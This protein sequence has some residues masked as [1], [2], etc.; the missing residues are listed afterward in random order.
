ML[1]YQGKW[2]EAIDAL[3]HVPRDVSPALWSYHM[4]WPL[5]SLNRLP[6]ASRML[7]TVL[8][9]SA[10]DPGGNLYGARAM[11]R[12]RWGDRKGAAGDISAA[13]RVGNGYGHFHHTAYSIAAVYSVLGDLDKAQEWIEKAA[14]DGFPCYTLFKADPNLEHLRR[15]TRFRSFVAK[16]RRE[17]EHIPR[18]LE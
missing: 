16:L 13:I 4:A 12:A 15:T 17:Y 3:N 8:A 11:I 10:S 18:E 6:E 9:Q 5:Q 7:E 1:N 2:E 14:Y